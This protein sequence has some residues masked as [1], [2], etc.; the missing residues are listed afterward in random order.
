MK[1][2]KII[3]ALSTSSL[4]TAGNN[5]NLAAGTH[6]RCQ[7]RNVRLE[8]VHD[9]GD[10]APVELLDLKTLA[11]LKVRD[12]ITG[13]IVAPTVAWMREAYAAGILHI[14][15]G[16]ESAEKRQARYALLDP[17]ACAD[18]DG[19]ARFRFSLAWR[20]CSD[21]V[22]KT[23]ADFANWLNDNFGKENSDLAFPRPSA[24]TLRRWVRSLEKSEKR[25][26]GLV[27][28]VGRQKGRS[29][30][31]PRV[32][33][34]TDEAAFWYW[35]RPRAKMVDA[36]AWLDNEI[37][38]LNA[39]LP[40]ATG[41]TELYKKPSKEAL[42]KRINRLRCYETVCAKEG[43]AAADRQFKSSGEPML[44]DEI[45]QVALMDAT[46][47]DQLIVFDKD[48]QLPSCRV[49]ITSLMDCVSHAVFGWAVYA[50]PNRAE[51]S[52]QAILSCMTPSDYPEDMVREHPELRNLFGRPAA[53][54]PDNE[55]AL[56]GPSSLPGLNEAG[57]MVLLPPVEMP[58]AK[59]SKERFYRSLKEALAQLPGT[60]IDPKYAKD[61]GYDAVGAAAIT[62]SQ[63][64]MI[65]A[66]VIASHNVS[67]CKGLDGMSPLQVWL[68]HATRRATPAFENL[69]HVQS[70]LGRTHKALLTNDCVE[71]DGIRYREAKRLQ[72]LIDNMG[73]S[74]ARRSQ[75]KDGSATVEVKI[76]RQDG[77]LDQ[78]EVYDTVLNE[79][80]VLPS[81]QP[82]YTHNLSAWE[83]DYFRKMAKK[84]REEFK[85]QKAR[86][87]SK[88]KTI[89]MIDTM[90]PQVPFQQ[91]REMAALYHSTQVRRLAGK[92]EHMT[93]PDD[94][95]IAPQIT[96]ET[97]RKDDGLP[98]PMAETKGKTKRKHQPPASPEG[99][100]GI[101]M[102]ESAAEFDWDSLDLEHDVARDQETGVEA[103]AE[104]EPEQ[105]PTSDEFAR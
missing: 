42:R 36:E 69:D 70:V 1:H 34:K 55:T 50:G 102:A 95:I 45:L 46:T 79:Y 28:L 81:T 41:R 87:T 98:A 17:D 37:D 47:L 82:E 85:T 8:R 2:D 13:E 71:F 25:I 68:Q 39:A 52:A 89:K 7:D 54:L 92:C 59:A 20:A 77:N 24:S 51:T 66:Q 60:V 57:I 76:R 90:A 48:W 91:R 80:V 43:K 38:Q 6:F 31:E 23:D 19:K 29:Q 78:I 101:T 10:D 30:L 99:Y 86:L 73:N 53:L 96:A 84:R 35:A 64:R 9:G 5:L 18:R 26:G 105:D 93:L 4:A 15:G 72:G 61:L 104:P 75:R 49:R 56:V 44:V 40:D 12:E 74:A 100:G 94:V 83:H 97:L 14:S 62:L 33:G 103:V 58:K 67:P 11:L 63:L 16:I 27:S 65:V 32:D 88:A 21:Q 3:A 22:K